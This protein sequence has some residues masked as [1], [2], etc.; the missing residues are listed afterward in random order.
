MPQQNLGKAL[1]GL[2]K[3]G[4]KAKKAPPKSGNNSMTIE[5]PSDHYPQGKYRG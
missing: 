1:A 3:P 4:G 5:T 2:S